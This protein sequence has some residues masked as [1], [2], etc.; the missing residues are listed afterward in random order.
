MTIF[1]KGDI[2]RLDTATGIVTDVAYDGEVTVDWTD[3]DERI[4]KVWF[5]AEALELIDE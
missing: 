1:Q 3:E 4:N 5:P 2:V